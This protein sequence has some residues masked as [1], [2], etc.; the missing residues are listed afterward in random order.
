MSLCAH[1]RTVSLIQINSQVS[2]TTQW[3]PVSAATLANE[4]VSLSRAE[5]SSTLHRYLAPTL[6]APHHELE[7]DLLFHPMHL[8]VHSLLTEYRESEARRIS[9]ES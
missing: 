1:F 6:G 9:V 4:Q 7:D 2:E 3:R 8:F 5:Q